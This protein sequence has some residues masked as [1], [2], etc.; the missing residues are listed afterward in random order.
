MEAAE[1]LVTHNPK[2]Q[3]L[4]NA[5]DEDFTV[6]G[7]RVSEALLR[8]N[9][10]FM[11]I[12]ENYFPMHRQDAVSSNTADAQLA[13][14]LMGSSS[15]AFKIYIEKGFVN[16]RQAIPIQYQTAIKLDIMGVWTEA[17]N[18][19]EHFM[20]YGQMVKDLN[21][22]YKQSRQVT[23]AIK[24]R[25]GQKAVD[26]IN[27]YINEL[28]NPN[29]E[30][31]RS[32]MDQ[33]VRNLRG[34]VA[35]AYLSWKT[36][37]IV[38]QAITSPAGYFG[39]MNPI[40]YTGALFEY[41]TNTESLWNEIT[42]LSPHMKHRMVNTMVELVKEQA[43]EHTD[44]KAK[45]ALNKFTNL[46]MKGL[47]WIDNMA[48]APGWL[49][50][51]RKEHSRLTKDAANVNMSE[52]DI[53][54]K[55]AQY[56]D[57]IVRLTQP[58]SRID[59]LIPLQKGNSE[60]GKAL[61]QFSTS[62]NIFWQNMRYDVPQSIRDKRFRSA[63]G[64]IMGYTMAGLILGAVCTGFDEG[65]DE[66]MKKKKLAWWSTTMFTDAFPII[67]SEVSHLAELMI[68]GKMQ[69]SSG[70]NLFPTL[71]RIANAA[72]TGVKG[73]QQGDYEKLLKAV[74][75]AVEAYATSQGLPVS[76]AKQLGRAFGIGDGDGELDFNPGAFLG[77]R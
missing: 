55:A 69:Y 76:G 38:L 7:Q 54:V 33:I 68:T 15:G 37:G 57:D 22:V 47:E 14:E 16:K 3:Q 20:A 2:Y 31:V 10:T 62:L 45:A 23:D 73:M 75:L 49:V 40:E 27:K 65:D 64:S 48:V 61:T 51:F 56:A 25:Y 13:R 9:N 29:R 58:D 77:R 44:N 39:Y 4:M 12:V 1:K 6:G 66:E 72:Q 70:I 43:K 60:L 67:G 34:N 41:I 19:E 50:A 30:K 18:N 74:S 59:D 35:A 52:K 71:Q 24:N 26:Y 42:E 36:S 32:S 53:R 46:G 21:G 11:P 63:A 8:Y 17:V 28:A 5:I